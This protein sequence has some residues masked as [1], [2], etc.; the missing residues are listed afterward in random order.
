MAP[1]RDLARPRRSERLAGRSKS[2]GIRNIRT[3]HTTILHGYALR[4]QASR[5]LPMLQGCLRE[6]DPT[7]G[8]D[9]TMPWEV[10]FLGRGFQREPGQPR[11]ARQSGGACNGPV[12]RYHPAGNHADH[13]PDRLY[14]GTVPDGGR[15]SRRRFRGLP[16]QEQF[17]K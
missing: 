7:T 12:G 9:D 11:A 15:A 5:L 16:R 10:Q 13:V 17:G 2:L 14:R 4:A 1:G 3:A 8:A 6:H